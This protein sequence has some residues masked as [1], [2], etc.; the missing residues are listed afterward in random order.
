MIDWQDL[1]ISATRKHLYVGE[2]VEV[3]SPGGNDS[4]DTTPPSTPAILSAVADSSTQATLT[5]SAA[6]DNVAVTGYTLYRDNNPLTTTSNLTFIDT[7]LSPSTTY[8]YFVVTHDAADNNSAPSANASVTTPAL[9]PDT[10]PPST[11][12][13]LSAVADSSTQATLTWSAATDNVAVTGYTLYRDNNPLT[14]T[15]NLTFID[16]TLSPSTTY[17]YFVVAHDAADNNSDP[18]ANASVTTPTLP[19][20]TPPSTPAIQSAVADS[21]TQA[22]LT[23][24]PATDNVGVTGYAIYRD[25]T[26]LDTTPDLT[27]VD[28]NLAPFTTYG[29]SVVAQDA[30]NN[31]SS[32]SSTISVTTLPEFTDP[33]GA[34]TIQAV[35]VDSDSQLTINWIP[36]PEDVLAGV[37]A[38]VNLGAAAYCPAMEQPES[39]QPIINIASGDVN[40]LLSKISSAQSGT[41]FLLEDGVY[42]LPSN[43]SL[44][45][46][47]PGLTIRS[48]SGN[49]EAVRI[50]G[51]YNN[52]S[53]NV[54]EFTVADV[55]LSQPTNHNIQVRGEKGIT[56]TTIYNVHLLDA[57]QQFVKV[58]TGDGT[59]GKFADYGLVAC[60]RI[61]YTTFSKGTGTSLPSYTNGVDILA[62]KGWVIRD[63]EFRRIRSE[64]GPA[65]PA[66]LVW[67]NS[68]DTII[69]RNLIVDS[70][71]G[72]ALGLSSP[73]TL[74]RGGADVLYDHQNG[75]VENN[76][77]LALTE[78][79]DAAIENNYALN[80]QV[81]HNTIYYH[82][83]LN[84]SVNW[85][86]EYRF[87]P[88]TVNISDNLT[89]FP[90]IVRS[91][92]PAQQG[93]LEGNITDAQANW[94]IDIMAENYHLSQ[95]SGGGTA[96]AF[97]L[98]RDGVPVGT[99][100]NWNYADSNLTPSTTYTYSVTALDAAD[101]ESTHSAPV[102]G[103][104]LSLADT[105]PPSTPMIQSA[106]VDSSTQA[107]LTWS[108]AT[109]NVAVTGYTLYRDNNPLA[110]TS[111]LSYV[112]SN[113][114]P[115]TTYAYFVVAHDAA[116]NN[117][118]PSPE[119]AVTT[120]TPPQ[121]TAVLTW[122]KNQES[123]LSYYRVYFGNQPQSYSTG[124]NVGLTST[125][126]TPHYI[127]TG[128]APGTYYFTVTAVDFAGN[129]SP[130]SLEGTKVIPN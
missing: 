85:S 29:Y 118:A 107:T 2:T 63:N 8:A 37:E 9:P 106:V 35:Q 83:G 45:I 10:T 87:G 84:H 89:N 104:T 129:E 98:Y 1:D 119:T 12:A 102:T 32:P 62:G 109:D 79:A 4:T 113:L 67:R 3:L 48:A 22:T 23:W 57:G 110:T 24:S 105:T 124:M 80:S 26:L 20:T 94:F 127:I 100:P 19:D 6:T 30:A 68:L 28:T 27:Y 86:I 52:I 90:I 21:S 56:G 78:P 72:I 108:A 66:I 111:N 126:N 77:I 103:T 49:R 17:A 128:L 61:E 65:G 40:D 76:V 114:S 88:T 34:P 74:S 59:L 116:D 54:D 50:E 55:T 117:S 101:N 16:T 130:Y 38:S 81:Q 11:P 5:W 115:S 70:W 75:L 73:H 51:G 69:R 123:D 97:T 44:E 31:V 121:G 7:T 25:N 125:P 18:S 42:V 64:A 36:A 58:S 92:L 60:S 39:G 91:P 95:S 93:T 96:T 82:E 112:D 14:T 33:H 71:R 99:T 122:Q 15:S 46:K 120:P 41:T 13:I 47:T 53:V 43:K